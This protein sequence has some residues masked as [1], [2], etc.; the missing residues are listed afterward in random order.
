MERPIDDPQLLI[1][2]ARSSR[3]EDEKVRMPLLHEVAVP[4]F[5]RQR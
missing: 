3:V 1:C 4:L 2:Q 5:D